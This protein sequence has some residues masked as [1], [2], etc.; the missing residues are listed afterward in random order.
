MTNRAQSY[1]IN[2]YICCL[3]QKHLRIDIAYKQKRLSYEPV[4]S[5]GTKIQT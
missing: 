1:K 3:M 4:Y 5:I 2:T